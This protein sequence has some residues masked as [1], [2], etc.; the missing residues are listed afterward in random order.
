MKDNNKKNTHTHEKSPY[1]PIEA[2]QI[3]GRFFL[4]LKIAAKQ[5]IN[6]SRSRSFKHTKAALLS[7]GLR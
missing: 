4:G 2:H 3:A 6:E 7:F 1:T 5:I